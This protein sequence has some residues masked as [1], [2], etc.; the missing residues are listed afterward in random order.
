M[1]VDSP[2]FNIE[3]EEEQEE[4]EE[5]VVDQEA[6]GH[7]VS[8]FLPSSV[9]RRR[10]DLMAVYQTPPYHYPFLTNQPHYSPC[11]SLATHLPQGDPA[12]QQLHS[13]KRGG[14]NDLGV[15]THLQTI[16]NYCLMS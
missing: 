14:R 9:D 12:H 10:V 8:R 4:K 5:E 13:E 15:Y 11:H 7:G 2:N 1:D 6:E 3:E 16:D